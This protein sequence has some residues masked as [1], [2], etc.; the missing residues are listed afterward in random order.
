MVITFKIISLKAKTYLIKAKSQSQV[1]G[2]YRYRVTT[3]NNS[4]RYEFS[5]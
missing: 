3:D 1:Q 5:L 2:V 4:R